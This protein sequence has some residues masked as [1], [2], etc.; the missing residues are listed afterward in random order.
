MP[1]DAFPHSLSQLLMLRQA[2]VHPF[3][4]EDGIG[5]AVRVGGRCLPQAALLLRRETKTEV[6]AEFVEEPLNVGFRVA[7]GHEHSMAHRTPG[8]FVTDSANGCA[9]VQQRRQSA[10]RL[11]YS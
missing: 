2:R 7:V 8:R 1:V 3:R 10:W 9:E 5:E 4:L 6:D 11:P